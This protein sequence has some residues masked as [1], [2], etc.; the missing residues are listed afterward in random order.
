MSLPLLPILVSVYEM[1]FKSPSLG[2]K[3]FIYVMRPLKRFR[4]ARFTRHPPM[5]P[6]PLSLTSSHPDEKLET[7]AAAMA[8]R[9]VPSPSNKS[10]SC[11]TRSWRCDT[12]SD[13][14]TDLLSEAEDENRNN[15]PEQ[16]NCCRCLLGV[17]SFCSLLSDSALCQPLTHFVCF[18][19][20][21]KLLHHHMTTNTEE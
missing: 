2:R 4:F 6:H 17:L 8:V 13:S 20:Y 1:V 19:L 12:C 14:N 3:F 16:T 21:M 5:L 18:T 15:W 9:H 11:V 10:L 7:T